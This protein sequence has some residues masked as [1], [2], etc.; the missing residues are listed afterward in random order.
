[1]APHFVHLLLSASLSSVQL[2]PDAPLIYFIISEKAKNNIKANKKCVIIDYF[3]YRS[4]T[5]RAL[6]SRSQDV[7]PLEAT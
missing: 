4:V 5:K 3:K 1:M 7:K 6:L 2:L